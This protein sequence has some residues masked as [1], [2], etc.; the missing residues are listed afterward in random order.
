MNFAFTPPPSSCSNTGGRGALA[1]ILPP[2]LPVTPP[3]LPV[4]PSLLPVSSARLARLCRAA[5]WVVVVLILLGDGVRAKE[6]FTNDF[7][8]RIDPNHGREQGTGVGSRG[9]G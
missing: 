4:L 2:S 8:V 5:A 9:Q 6:I 1:D 3:S 7:Y